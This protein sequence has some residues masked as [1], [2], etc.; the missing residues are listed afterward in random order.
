MSVIN[1]MLQDLEKRQASTNAIGHSAALNTDVRGDKPSQSHWRRNLLLFVLGFLS[2]QLVKYFWFDT[3][4][5][6]ALPQFQSQPQSQISVASPALAV[7]ETVAS[8]PA[9]ALPLSLTETAAAGSP[10]NTMIPA[11]AQNTAV[12]SSQNAVVL[13]ASAQPLAEIP[14]TE[15][16]VTENPTKR[17][18]SKEQDV[19]L[20]AEPTK[21]VVVATTQILPPANRS[22]G[23]Q[24]PASIQAG[25]GQLAIEQSRP[26]FLEQQMSQAAAL[27]AAGQLQQALLELNSPVSAGEFPEYLALRAAILQQQQDWPAALSLYQQ[28]LTVEPA[29]PGWNLAAGIAAAQQGQQA[30]A[31]QYYQ[32][33]WQQQQRLAPASQQ[34]LQ[35]QLNQMN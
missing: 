24:A 34:F 26:S 16:S 6:L 10:T 18:T 14:E 3:D 30:L 8:E 29:H 7:T 19:A 32:Q 1:K 22:S 4:K 5:S 31:R 11:A 35:Q 13:V 20:G 21:P 15:N 9:T 23:Q 33:A 17:Q 12:I 2:Y 27:V 28:L 25:S